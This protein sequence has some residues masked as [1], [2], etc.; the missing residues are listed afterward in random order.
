MTINWTG[1]VKKGEHCI[2]FSLIGQTPAN[3]LPSG[4][5]CVRLDD[6]AAV[7]AE[8]QPALAVVGEYGQ[9]KG[10]IVILAADHLYGH[11]LTCAGIHSVLA[12][13]DAP[14]DLDWDFSTGVLNVVVTRPTILQLDLLTT[15]KLQLDGEP[16]KVERTGETYK[17]SLPEGRHVLRDASP[18][19]DARAAL[20]T[21]L[22]RL[23]AQGDRVSR[24][25]TSVCPLLGKAGC[26]S[27]AGGVRGTRWRQGA[28][29]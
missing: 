12:S 4:L 17:I 3:K 21:A 28:L 23:L 22:H 8:P 27:V 10:E 15:G 29:R 11:A 7:I 5:A 19:I 24:G 2:A 26:S 6:H 9:A 14:L 16:A 1:A 20:E 13:S 18:A 25:G